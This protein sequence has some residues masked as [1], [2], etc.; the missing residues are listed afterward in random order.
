MV[1]DKR[2]IARTLVMR[3]LVRRMVIPTLLWDATPQ[4]RRRGRSPITLSKLVG[5]SYDDGDQTE[6]YRALTERT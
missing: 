3:R 4:G 2:S 5:G 1:R 6:L